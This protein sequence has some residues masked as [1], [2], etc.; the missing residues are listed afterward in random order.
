[1]VYTTPVFL[2]RQPPAKPVEGE[3]AIALIRVKKTSFGKM[4]AGNATAPEIQGG[5]VHG[6]TKLITH[7]MEMSISHRDRTEV[8]EESDLW[9]IEEGYRS[10]IEKAM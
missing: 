9:K 10:D 5:H 8:S 7:E 1:M 6:R 2:A 4:E 3:K